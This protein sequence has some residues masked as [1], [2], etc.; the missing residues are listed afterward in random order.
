MSAG[1]DFPRRMAVCLLSLGRHSR[2]NGNLPPVSALRDPRFRGD[3]EEGK[4]VRGQSD[5]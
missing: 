1:I 3:D 5:V 2:E 4:W